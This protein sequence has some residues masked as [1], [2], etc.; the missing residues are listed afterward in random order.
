MHGVP[1]IS[2]DFVFLEVIN[3]DILPGP[4][5]V[6]VIP[7]RK[8]KNRKVG[9]VGYPAPTKYLTRAHLKKYEHY[10]LRVNKGL[11]AALFD[12]GGKK[13]VSVGYCARNQKSDSAIV[14]HKCPSEQAMSGALIVPL[15]SKKTLKKYKA[16]G[17]IPCF[18]IRTYLFMCR[19]WCV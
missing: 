15:F 1:L 5:M 4:Y 10:P 8:L 14:T 6:P 3:N 9:M 18:A 16:D 12:G 17:L 19:C 13:I 11:L 2:N 7:T